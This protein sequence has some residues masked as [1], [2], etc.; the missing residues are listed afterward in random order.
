MEQLREQ[1]Q[2]FAE[3]NYETIGFFVITIGNAALTI[4]KTALELSTPLLRDFFATF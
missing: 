3:D 2:Q 4:A 1:L